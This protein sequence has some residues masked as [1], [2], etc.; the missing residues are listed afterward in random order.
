MSE[1]NWKKDGHTLR[2][3]C[4]YDQIR[5]EVVCPGEGKCTAPGPCIACTDE[6]GFC[7]HQ[8]EASG[9]CECKR[10]HGTCRASNWYCNLVEW[11]TAIAS[12]ID[13]FHDSSREDISTGDE[14]EWAW[15]DEGPIWRIAAGKD[16]A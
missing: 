9:L 14:I 15:T 4:D 1:R 6:D 11:T 12:S 16:A 3:V 10:C 8:G 2:V 5:A 7:T 13:E